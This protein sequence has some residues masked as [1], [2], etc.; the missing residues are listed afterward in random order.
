MNDL[1]IRMFKVHISDEAIANMNSVLKSG[2][3]GEGGQVKK[4]ESRFCEET[5][6]N[7]ALA[8]NSGTSA[9]HLALVVAGVRPNDEVITTAQTM[10]ATSHA[11]LMQFAK[12]VFADVQYDTGNIDPNDIEHRITSKTKAVLPVHWGG[13]PCNMDEIHAIAKRHG[14]VVIED[15]AHALGAEYRNKKIGAVS[16]ITCFSL[17]AIKHITT[18][19]G[20]MMTFDKKDVYDDARLRR[21]FGID[22]DNRRPSVL[23]EPIWDVDRVGYK[24]H[25]N[26][27]AASLGVEH[28]DLLPKFLERRRK[29]AKRYQSELKNITGVELLKLDSDRKGAY[30]LFTIH[31]ERREEFARMMLSKGVEVSVIH[32]RID[33]NKIFG[34]KRDD[35]PNLDRFDADQIALPI[36]QALSDEDVDYVIK[37]IKE[38]W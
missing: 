30:W 5:K 34:P 3:V 2:Y 24:Y 12:P 36:H 33:S 21:W 37:A 6:S 31:V 27:I 28:M 32:Q 26:D 22:R 29:T 8:V 16:D 23:G 7:H 15:G 38:G 13:M 11:I 35:L 4:L 20:G 14:L 17:Q 19:D 10:M 25:M 1:K 18:G 9:L